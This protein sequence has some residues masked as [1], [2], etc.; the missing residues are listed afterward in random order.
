[1]KERTQIKSKEAE[2][3]KRGADDV[4]HNAIEVWRDE[5][6]GEGIRECSEGGKQRL[7]GSKSSEIEDRKEQEHA[8][9]KKKKVAKQKKYQKKTEDQRSK[10]TQKKKKKSLRKKQDQKKKRIRRSKKTQ[11]RKK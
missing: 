4:S 9:K 1:M 11:K 6:K 8:G 7:W 2:D 10:K 3:I 5:D